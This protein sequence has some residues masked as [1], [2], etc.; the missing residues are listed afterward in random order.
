MN[1]IQKF[2][3]RIGARQ[4]GFF[5]VALIVAAAFLPVNYLV[6]AMF[7][8]GFI[9]IAAAANT[10]DLEGEIQGLSQMTESEFLERLDRAKPR[11]QTRLVSLRSYN[12]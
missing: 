5:G 10:A 2:C 7:V 11:Q 12:G 4:L 6:G 3:L 9:G 1:S 8:V